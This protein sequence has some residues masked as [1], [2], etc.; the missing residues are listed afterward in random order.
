MEVL[1]SRN[2]DLTR[3]NQGPEASPSPPLA[4]ILSRRLDDGRYIANSDVRKLIAELEES[5]RQ[6]GESQ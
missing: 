2:R 4:S 1:M 6:Y 3:E 5:E